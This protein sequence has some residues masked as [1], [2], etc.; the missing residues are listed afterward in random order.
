MHTFI[1]PDNEKHL[2]IALKVA[3]VSSKQFE[4]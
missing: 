1:S 2:I 3:D 4:N